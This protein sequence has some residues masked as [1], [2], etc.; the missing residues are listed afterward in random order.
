MH[1]CIFAVK[2]PL[3]KL[4]W[5]LKGESGC[6]RHTATRDSR[7]ERTQGS[8]EICV[9][10]VCFVV[11]CCGSCGLCGFDGWPEHSSGGFVTQGGEVEKSY[12]RWGAAAGFG[13][14]SESSGSWECI[15]CSSNH[16][17][18]TAHT[19]TVNHQVNQPQR[20]CQLVWCVR[21]D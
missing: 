20:V 2:V 3:D 10:F 1:C 18:G 21:I 15:T 14:G 12:I 16:K 8:K 6:T 4:V 19:K 7:E 17:G 9:C 5:I 11:C 13:K